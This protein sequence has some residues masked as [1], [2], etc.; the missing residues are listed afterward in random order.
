M[1]PERLIPPSTDQLNGGMPYPQPGVG[2]TPQDSL[3]DWKSALAHAQRLTIGG[4]ISQREHNDIRTHARQAGVIPI[5]SALFNSWDEALSHARELH[6]QGAISTP[7]FVEINREAQ[8]AMSQ[9]KT[10]KDMLGQVQ[11][12]LSNFDGPSSAY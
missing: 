1:S 5:G 8:L 9:K 12:F 7:E 6:K 2:S 10:P 4:E 11:N 3:D